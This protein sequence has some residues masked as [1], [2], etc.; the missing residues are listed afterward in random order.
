M[1]KQVFFDKLYE[2]PTIYLCFWQYHSPNRHH[3]VQRLFPKVIHS[4]L[5]TLDLLVL[6]VLFTMILKRFLERL[7]HNVCIL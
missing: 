5:I 2:P 3:D 1:H 4:N 7:H 6:N